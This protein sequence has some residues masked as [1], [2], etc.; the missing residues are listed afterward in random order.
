M[1]FLRTGTFCRVSEVMYVLQE[2]ASV[3]V[4][5]FTGYAA[6]DMVEVEAGEH[7]AGTPE[8]DYLRRWDVYLVRRQLEYNVSIFGYA[9][10]LNSI[11]AKGFPCFQLSISN[12]LSLVSVLSD[13][14]KTRREC[15]K[16][17]P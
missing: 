12:V 16:I 3:F 9:I 15:R 7:A 17:K 6:I 8:G 1:L 13:T 5:D 4:P 11:M 10:L 2:L 14:S